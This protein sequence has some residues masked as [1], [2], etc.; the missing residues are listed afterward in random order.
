M[1]VSPPLNPILMLLEGNGS[2]GGR[3]RSGVFTATGSGALRYAVAPNARQNLAP[4]PYLTADAT[5]WSAGGTRVADPDF[6]GG[7]AYE[8]TNATVNQGGSINVGFWLPIEEDLTLSFDVK[9]MSGEQAQWYCYLAQSGVGNS[10]GLV[11]LTAGDLDG[12][13]HRVSTNSTIR[14]N[15]N[16]FNFVTALNFHRGASAP[17]DIS[18]IRVGNVVLERGIV[19]NP[20][21]IQPSIWIDPRTGY[22]VAA[23][24]AGA[25]SRAAFWL[26]EATTNLITNPSVE[27]DSTG[28]NAPNGGTMTWVNTHAFL[29]S[30]SLKFERLDSGGWRGVGNFSGRTAAT[31]GQ[32]FTFSAWVLSTDT[33]LQISCFERDAGGSIVA[34]SQVAVSGLV[35]GSWRRIARTY[36]ATS[37][38]CATLEVRV[39]T[40]VPAVFYLDCMQL[41]Q[42]AYATSYCDGSLGTGHSW[43]GTAHASASSRAASLVNFPGVNRILADIGSGV[44]R[45]TRTVDTNS[46]QSIWALSGFNSAG[47]TFIE[48]RI[49]STSDR[50]QVLVQ[51]NGV[52][53]GTL[54]SAS[55]GSFIDAPGTWVTSYADWSLAL[56]TCKI[57]K[58]TGTLATGGVTDAIGSVAMFAVGSRGGSQPLDGLVGP[59]VTY[60]KPLSDARRALVNTA[61]DSNGAIDLW[62]LFEEWETVLSPV[63]LFDLETVNGAVGITAELAPLDLLAL[64]SGE[65]TAGV[66]AEVEAVDLDLSGEEISAVA[67]DLS[68]GV[69]HARPRA[70]IFQAGPKVLP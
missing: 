43:A 41:E 53:I 9:W 50:L 64:Q 38:T 13:L 57:G 17:S 16:N 68:R 29:G 51:N 8:I 34:S 11:Q 18:T 60:E 55:D 58:L 47:T 19:A 27:I 24:S 62:T 28:W 39:V 1:T 33:G 14:A 31:Q 21:K 7:W 30:R 56:A 48:T 2:L 69:F 12:A 54:G 6:D 15:L 37:A 20:T 22:P 45:H 40:S 52:G 4:N 5:G 26:D 32:T 3:D 67:L 70:A 35:A 61:I 44:A 36:T 10:G 23:N 25:T 59:V 63:D 46:L 66:T 49:I 65:G 42:K